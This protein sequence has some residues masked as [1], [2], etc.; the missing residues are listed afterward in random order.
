MPDIIIDTCP[1]AAG[2]GE[3]SGD[4]SSGD[5]NNAVYIDARAY[6]EH[7]LLYKSDL[8][9]WRPQRHKFVLLPGL[10]AEFLRRP[11]IDTEACC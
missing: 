7:Q 8:V 11:W 3:G 10:F 9:L 1:Q 4:D 2:S 6:L 5:W